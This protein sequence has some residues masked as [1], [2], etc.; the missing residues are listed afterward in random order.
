MTRES[1]SA[2]VSEVQMRSR[3]VRTAIFIGVPLLATALCTIVSLRAPV[4]I[5][6]TSASVTTGDIVRHLVTTGV[7]QPVTTVDVGTQVSGTIQEVDVDY[8]AIVR[9]GQ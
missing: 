5:N 9:V 4:D 8:N 6:V 3:W 2:C 7:L 1:G